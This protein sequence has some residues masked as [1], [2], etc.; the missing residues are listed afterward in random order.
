M[1]SGFGAAATASQVGLGLSGIAATAGSGGLLAAGKQIVDNVSRSAGTSGTVLYSGGQKA[2]QAATDFA[3]STGGKTIEM[4]QFGKMADIAAQANRSQFV[5]IW[6][7]ASA[8]FCQQASGTVNAFVY[9]PEYRGIASTFW[10]VEMPTLLNNPR[11]TDIVIH[12][13]GE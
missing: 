11:V 8:T 3:K 5:P 2:A 7:Q 4:T 13:F 12:V 9:A 6:N 1:I 10:S